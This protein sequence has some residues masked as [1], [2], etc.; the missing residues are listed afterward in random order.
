MFASLP[1]FLKEGSA[2]HDTLCPD[3]VI[4]GA[5]APFS[6]DM[7]SELH[8]PFNAPIVVMRPESAQ[9]CKYASN[10]YL[11]TR[12]TFINQIANLCEVNGA[13]ISEVIKGIGYDNRIGSHYWYP[14][15]GYGGSC[16]PKDVRELA[17][18]A[19]GVGLSDN[20][21][22]RINELNEERIQ[23]MLKSYGDM[24]GGWK[25]KRVAVLGLS[26]KPNT[27]DMREAPSTKQFHIL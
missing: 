12:I 7:L 9:M 25:G 17:A 4:I 19:R 2:V 14:G 13:D 5:D 10:A 16:F 6:I 26:F 23:H 8:K 15:T 22:V 24:I 1:E 27:D 20:L 18:Y 21:M 11:A 3:R